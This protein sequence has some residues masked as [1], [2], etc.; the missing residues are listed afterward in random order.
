[1]VSFRKH[2]KATRCF[3]LPVFLERK[4]SIHHGTGGSLSF[5]LQAAYC[6]PL[7]RSLDIQQD[8][9]G[10][11]FLAREDFRGRFGE[12]LPACAFFFFFFLNGD[13]LAQIHST[14]KGNQVTNAPRMPKFTQASTLTLAHA[15]ARTH[16]HT[17]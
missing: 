11:F 1:M 15:R 6:L 17:Q 7:T 9:G 2:V 14:S 13:R 8:G 16:T 4:Q 10:G 12:S 3:S 5:H